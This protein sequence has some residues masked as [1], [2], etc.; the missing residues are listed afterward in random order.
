M[1]TENA[2]S[3]N[4][5][6]NMWRAVNDFWD[7][8]GLSNLSDVFNAAGNWQAVTTLTAGH[9]ADGDMLPLGYLGPRNEWHA[10]GQTTF[11][12]A[13]QVTIMSLWSIMP[14]PLMFGGNVQS[15]ASDDWTLGLLTNEE[16]MAVNQDAS[17]TH[18]KR[19]LQQG[20]TEVWMRDLTGGRK[21][22]ALFNRGGQDAVVSVTFSQLGMTGTPAVR[23]LW[24]RTEVTDLT[25]SLSA[26]VPSNGASMYILTPTE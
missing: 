14:S 4:A 6:A 2:V 20:G 11:S 12:E 22:A 26:T 10:S 21:A 16:V 15:L 8:N 1:L 18:G 25:T 23:D 9:W 19:I 24:N 3:L 17:G 13:E 5:N 7:Y